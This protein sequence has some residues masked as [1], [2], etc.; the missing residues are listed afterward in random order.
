MKKIVA[1]SFE[2]YNCY[3][4]IV[5]WPTMN[6]FLYLPRTYA[7]RLFGLGGRVKPPPK[8]LFVL[9]GLEDFDAEVTGLVTTEFFV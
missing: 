1:G 6:F 2:N 3:F 8:F 5:G 4:G 7:K 9:C